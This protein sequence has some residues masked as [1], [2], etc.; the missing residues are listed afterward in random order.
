M[1]YPFP[2]C[3]W[4][5]ASSQTRVPYSREVREQMFLWPAAVRSQLTGARTLA[6]FFLFSSF[7]SFLPLVI[8]Y[9]YA[10]LSVCMCERYEWLALG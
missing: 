2:F 8:H 9:A 7:F 6:V 4:W 1:N 5:Q 3:V 10:L